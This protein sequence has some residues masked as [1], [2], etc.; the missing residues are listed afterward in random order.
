MIEYVD[1]LVILCFVLFALGAGFILG[2]AYYENENKA[3]GFSHCNTYGH[4][5][6]EWEDY[7]SFTD[8]KLSKDGSHKIDN[9]DNRQKITCINCNKRY[10]RSVT[11]AKQRGSY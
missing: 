2:K 1:G 10:D 3:L 11:Y 9:W 6:G 5:W 4:D 8:S 7:Q